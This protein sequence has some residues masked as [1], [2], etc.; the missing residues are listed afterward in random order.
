MDTGSVGSREAD[1]AA[2]RAVEA[3]YDAAWNAGD[4]KT[5]LQLL[6]EGVVVTNP[7]GETTVG[8]AEL[9][10]SFSA[11]FSGAAKGSTHESR[12]RAVHFVTPEVALVDAEAVISDFGSGTE[13]LRH[14]FADVLVRTAEGWRIDHIRAFA[15]LPRPAT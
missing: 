10:A 11:L 5:L 15:Y 9:E 12:I 6:T 4:L 13:P 1:D 8:R 7:Y 2:V 3:A 14:G